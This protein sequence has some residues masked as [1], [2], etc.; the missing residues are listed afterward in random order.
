MERNYYNEIKEQLINFEVYKKVK[1][2]SKNRKELET[3]YNVG[4]LIIEAQGGEESRRSPQTLRGQKHSS[5]LREEQH[6]DTLQL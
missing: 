3:Y 6:Q 5:H 4:K 2:Y 1:E